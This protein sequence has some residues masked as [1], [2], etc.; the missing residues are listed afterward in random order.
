MLVL[1]DFELLQPRTLKEAVEAM[2]SSPGEVMPL[3][4]GTDLIPNLKHGLHGPR[5]IVS[6]KRVDEL[7]ATRTDNGTCFFGAGM[8]LD[9]LASHP[10]AL[11][12]YPALAEAAS[13]VAGPQLRRMGTLGGNICLDSRCVYYNQTHFWRNALGYCLKKDGT[14]CF[15]VPEGSRCVAALS[16]DTPGPLIAYG[17]VIHLV[18]PEGKRDLP[19]GKFF[20][21]DG[22]WNTVRKPDELVTGVTLPA[23][24]PGLYSAYKKLRVREAIDFPALSIAVSAELEDDRTVR[25]MMLVVGALAAKPR[26]ISR[27]DELVAGR[28]LDR[29]LMEE[30]GQLAYKQCHPMTSINVDPEWR[31]EVLPVYVRRA[32][33]DLTPSR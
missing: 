28:K 33:E 17:A 11:S 19:A 32:L 16:A 15:V 1:P 10:V 5:K 12:R 6:L 30:V 3:A 24:T 7:K 26:V 20:K 8:T 23:P 4:G 2:S 29:E 27:L 18:S 25:T 13:T 21:A 9:A 22:I 31:R 14:A